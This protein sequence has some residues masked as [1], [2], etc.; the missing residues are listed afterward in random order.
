MSQ[1]D[2]VLVWMWWVPKDARL[3]V[4]VHLKVSLLQKYYPPK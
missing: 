4:G 2:I 3:R 1:V